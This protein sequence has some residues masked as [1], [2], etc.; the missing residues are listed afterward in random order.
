MLQITMKPKTAL[1]A[2]ALAFS[3]SAQAQTL[4]EGI[5][6]YNYEKYES[7]K[8]V[9]S[10]LAGSNPT[11]NYY[12]GL[13]EL[14]QGNVEAAK[15][16]FAKV[17]DNVANQSGLARVSFAEGKAAEGNQMAQ[18]IA[19]KAKKKDWETMKLA[20]DAVN[21]SKGGNTQQAIDWYKNALAVQDNAELHIAIADAYQKLQSGGGEA[22]SNY[23]RVTDKDAKN[24]LAFSRV[25]KLWYDARN[26]ELALQNWKKAS[27][28]D[29]S[30]PVPYRDLSSA[31]AA[32]GKYDLALQ[33]VEKYYELSDKTTEDKLQ[34]MD[35]MFLSK[36]YDKAVQLANEIVAS[37]VKEPR[38]YG[39]LGFS[40]YELKDYANAQ[41]NAGIYITQQDP[42]KVFPADYIQYGRILMQSNQPDSANAYFNRAIA[43]DTA[44][45]KS[46]TY[47]DIAEAFKSAKDYKKAA[48]WYKRIVDTDPAVT[49]TD[50]FWVGA[51]NYYGSN[52]QDAATAFEQMET[53][54]PDQ[55]SATYW[56]GRVGAAVDNEGKQGTAV[57]FYTKW[58][59]KVGANYD[60]KNDLMQAYQY[61]L[62]YYYNNNDKVNQKKYEDLVLSI[63]PN[64][65]LV[66]QI[67]SSQAKGK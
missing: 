44:K 8:K 18:G 63:E 32:S 5:K 31:Y 15:A 26:Y 53:K 52:F 30:N 39:L 46:E 29:P 13:T 24:S 23:E 17:P 65:D 34:Y 45:V 22:M 36:N 40:Q 57:P 50:Y 11:A 56:R 3:F 20:A 43:M 47:R 38:V 27:D 10:P 35:L 62:L 21:Y 4:E 67:K 33:N 51:M 59:E 66:K 16:I 2:A 9:L 42:K 48:E 6:L 55:P 58:L 41:K 7:A 25:G 60:K 1:V 64:N 61:M 54:F 49:A 12:L 28:A 14:Q 19:G 37:G